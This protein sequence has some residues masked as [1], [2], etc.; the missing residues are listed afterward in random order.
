MKKIV[1]FLIFGFS[2]FVLSAQNVDTLAVRDYAEGMRL[3]A[4]GEYIGAL[5]SFQKV[6]DRQPRHDPS[7]YEIANIMIAAGQPNQA[8]IF[9]TKAL[10]IDPDNIWYKRQNGRLLVGFGLYDKALPIYEE[11]A[12]KGH[13]LET[14]VTLSSLY[15]S[16]KR[17]DEAIEI[18]EKS[19]ALDPDNLLVLNNLAY[20]LAETGRDLERALELSRTAIEQRPDEA[21]FLDT[22]AWAL[23]KMGNYAQAKQVMM[24][25]LPL[26]RTGSSEMLMHYGD[27]L[28]ALGDDFLAK[29]Y[30]KRAL[31]A[32]YEPKEEIEERLG[33]VR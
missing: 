10:E 5:E 31:E 13:D 21:T 20:Y 30:W 29:T 22:H 3:S 9:S 26:D 17:M 2:F 23:Y 8:L 11:L 19:H 16:A 27:I 6:L 33:R 25:A 28:W 1:L 14:L 15:F 4:Q 32:G 12:A 7:M 24:K 18:A